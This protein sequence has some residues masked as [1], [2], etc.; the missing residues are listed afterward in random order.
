MLVMNATN[1]LWRIAVK[2]W[3]DLLTS[4]R[5]LPNSFAFCTCEYNE[6]AGSNAPDT[7]HKMDA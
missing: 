5:S 4:R 2:L 7:C 3:P 6:S 1:E